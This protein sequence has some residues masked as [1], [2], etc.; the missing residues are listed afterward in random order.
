MCVCVC[1]CVWGAAALGSC[2]IS[3]Y[4][5]VG[6][7][8]V[9]CREIQTQVSATSS[10]LYESVSSR[11]TESVDNGALD[12]LTEIVFSFASARKDKDETITPVLMLKRKTTSWLQFLWLL[13]LNCIFEEHPHHR[14]LITKVM[15]LRQMGFGAY[16]KKAVTA[17]H[18]FTSPL[19]FNEIFSTCVFPFFRIAVNRD[20]K[21][22]LCKWNNKSTCHDA[23]ACQSV[24]SQP[25]QVMATFIKTSG[26]W[27]QYIHRS[28]LACWILR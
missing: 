2:C 18:I 6:S 12:Q 24:S 14:C 5:C 25:F 8:E 16:F 26:S 20:V 13:Y 27:L 4:V 10:V 19:C 28:A 11:C 23:M 15:A 3:V 17:A 7:H 9:D 22:H 21:A 1:V